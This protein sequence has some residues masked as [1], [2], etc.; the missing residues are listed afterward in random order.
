MTI[1]AHIF[2]LKEGGLYVKKDAPLV[3][4]RCP[5]D[6]LEMLSVVFETF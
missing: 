3:N 1:Y 6:L 5:T 2:M 4:Q